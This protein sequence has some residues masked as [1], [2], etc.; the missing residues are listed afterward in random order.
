MRPDKEGLAEN[1]YRVVK[2]LDAVWAH[3]CPSKPG[4]PLSSDGKIPGKEKIRP[5]EEKYPPFGGERRTV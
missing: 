5:A 1:T 2:G 4:L 3:F